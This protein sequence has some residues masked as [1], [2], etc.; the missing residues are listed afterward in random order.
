MLA[1]SYVLRREV[2]ALIDEGVSYIQLDSL[3][4]VIQLADPRIRQQMLQAGQDLDRALDETIATD[5]ATLQDARGAGV[6]VG[7]HMC[8]G[9]NRSA[10]RTT[11]SYEVIAEKAF[12]AGCLRT[13]GPWIL[14][15]AGMTEE[16]TGMGQVHTSH[17]PSSSK[18]A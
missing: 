4:Y 16:N 8:R 13:V 5:N 6:T 11:G 15:F 18:F 10:W 2:K 12:T 7:L 17:I 14:A 1:V 3:R 9:N